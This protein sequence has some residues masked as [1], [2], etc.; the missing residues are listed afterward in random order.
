MTF[1]F[2]PLVQSGL[3][4][5]LEVLFEVALLGEAPGSPL[6]LKGLDPLVSPGVVKHVPCS[7][8]LFSAPRMFAFVRGGHGPILCVLTVNGFVREIL[9][10]LQVQLVFGQ[11][12]LVSVVLVELD[13]AVRFGLHDNISNTVFLCQLS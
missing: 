3:K 12:W 6:A 9:Q 13:W 8:K 1:E 11:T 10:K 4:V 5:L 7:T 2:L